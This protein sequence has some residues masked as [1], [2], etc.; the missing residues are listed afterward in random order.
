MG[1]TLTDTNPILLTAR[2]S[3][4]DELVLAYEGS[5]IAD[6]ELAVELERLSSAHVAIADFE[7]DGVPYRMNVSTVE[8]TGML[9]P[10]SHDGRSAV[11][12]T[13]TPGEAE[14]V[15]D[16]DASAVSYAGDAMPARL[17]AV[18]VSAARQ[19]RIRI[20]VRRRGSKPLL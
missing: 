1:T 18:F 7:Q 6:D 19:R 8:P 3:S 15:V 16:A 10:W 5:P 13:Y 20:R 2:I 9:T 17:A 12:E 11:S 14:I 4:G